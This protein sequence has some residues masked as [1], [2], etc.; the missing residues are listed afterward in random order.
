MSNQKLDAI[1]RP[2]YR[3]LS[4]NE[5]AQMA[6]IKQSAIALAIEFN[7]A[8]TREKQIAMTK[9]EECVMWAVKGVTG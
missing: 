4:I 3:E 1:F 5:K 7:P 2:E 8:D 6:R 9:L